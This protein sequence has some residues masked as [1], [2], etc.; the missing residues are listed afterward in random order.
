MLT[1]TRAIILNALLASSIL[2]Q[3][4]ALSIPVNATT[5]I[6]LQDSQPSLT[7]PEHDYYAAGVE[8]KKGRDLK[9][10]KKP[11]KDY[12]CP[13]TDR[14]E[15]T[16][17]TKNQVQKAYME[18]AKRANKGIQL[19]QRKSICQFPLLQILY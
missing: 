6:D 8:A 14:Y 2:S 1:F 19:G 13:H 5:S 9:I 12:K 15:E 17:Y 11:T 7:P 18:A 4:T 10:Q 16:T 3:V